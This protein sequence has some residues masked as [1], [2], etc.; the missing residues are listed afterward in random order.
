MAF[1]IAGLRAI[2]PITIQNCQNVA[3]S[4]PGFA[5][6]AQQAGIG[7]IEKAGK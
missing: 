1:V 6:T 5:A 4:F 7:L 2:A 3:T